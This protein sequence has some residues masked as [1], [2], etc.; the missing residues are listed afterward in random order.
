ML[1]EKINQQLETM[2]ESKLKTIIS[3]YKN[4]T[5]DISTKCLSRLYDRAETAD[6]SFNNTFERIEYATKEKY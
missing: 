5:I 6:V 3:K 1:N 4:I 2:E